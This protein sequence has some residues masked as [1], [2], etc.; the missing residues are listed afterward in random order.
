MNSLSPA[1]PI[2]GRRSD[3]ASNCPHCGV[4]LAGYLRSYYRP[5]SCYNRALAHAAAGHVHAAAREAYAATVLSPQQY[6]FRLLLSRL[7][8]AAGEADEALSQAELADEL[9]P[10]NPE[11]ETWLTALLARKYET[12]SK[13]Q[14]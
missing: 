11:V 13:S 14:F 5:W 6:E 3:A 7:L 1:C 9:S 2:C 4:S 12:L 8:D 10:D